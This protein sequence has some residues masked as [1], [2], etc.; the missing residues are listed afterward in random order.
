M[1]PLSADI[2]KGNYFQ[3]SLTTILLNTRYFYH[4]KHTYY[5]QIKPIVYIQSPTITK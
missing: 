3:R 1:F 5:L 2:Y 4:I